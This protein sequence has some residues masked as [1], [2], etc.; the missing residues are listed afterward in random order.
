MW[1][2]WILRSNSSP[3]LFR[4][5][6]FTDECRSEQAEKCQRCV[7]FASFELVKSLNR[8]IGMSLPNLANLDSGVTITCRPGSTCP[9]GQG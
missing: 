7:C 4:G 3:N 9:L 2:F 6:V 5:N 8:Y 1:L